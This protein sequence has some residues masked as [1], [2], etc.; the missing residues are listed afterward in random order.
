M[1]AELSPG[2]ALVHGNGLVI[3]HA[4]TVKSGC[5]L[6]H[7]VTL[8]EGMDP[9]T[10]ERG[11]PTLEEGV[12]VGPGATLLGPITVGAGTKIMAGAVLNRSRGAGRLARDPGSRHRDGATARAP[13]GR[14]GRAVE[15][16]AG[17]GELT[18]RD[19]RGVSLTRSRCG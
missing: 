14:R 15:A 6:F 18:G 11:A 5:I 10:R 1:D 2:I 4:A 9:E 12:H 7:N 3:S 13:P 8:G 16:R 19:D 17:R